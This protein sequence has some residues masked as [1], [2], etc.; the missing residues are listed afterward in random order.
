MEYHGFVAFRLDNSGVNIRFDRVL[1]PAVD[2]VRLVRSFDKQVRS[3]RMM[4][5]L[6]AINVRSIC[7]LCLERLS[8]DGVKRLLKVMVLP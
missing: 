8:K 3:W 2:D 1:V 4:T 6:L 7:S 5:R